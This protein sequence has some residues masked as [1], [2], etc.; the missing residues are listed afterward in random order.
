M[1]QRDL[2]R[3]FTA[4]DFGIWLTLPHFVSSVLYV[5][6]PYTWGITNESVGACGI[7]S[8]FVKGCDSFCNSLAIWLKNTTSPYDLY[9]SGKRIRSV[10]FNAGYVNLFY[11][12]IPSSYLI[13]QAM[14]CHA[15]LYQCV[16]GEDYITLHAVITWISKD[17]Q[18]IPRTL[19][20]H[21]C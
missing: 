15:Y 16:I 3:V 13:Y 18:I 4:Q 7:F 14:M 11:L 19:K 5:V 17:L 21:K 12:I 20:C 10:L 9:F 1:I 2:V 6:Q 8:V